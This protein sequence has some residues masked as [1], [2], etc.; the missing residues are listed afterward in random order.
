MNVTLIGDGSEDT[1]NH[2]IFVDRKW[3]SELRYILGT[4][5][6]QIFVEDKSL[7]KDVNNDNGV[8]IKSK[9][10]ETVLKD[11]LNKLIEYV[12]NK[13]EEIKHEGE[14]ILKILNKSEIFD[15]DTTKDKPLAMIRKYGSI[16]KLENKGKQ[17]AFHFKGKWSSKSIKEPSKHANK[18]LKHE[19]KAI[20]LFDVDNEIK[21]FEHEPDAV[22]QISFDLFFCADSVNDN[23]R[24]K[25]LGNF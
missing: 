17:K 6:D 5:F 11:M 24:N 23:I 20:K 2:F 1:R 12:N 4:G 15:I 22:E 9:K 3:M 19:G 21:D 18:M 16:D 8:L 7:L 25:F 14:T 10:L 13:K